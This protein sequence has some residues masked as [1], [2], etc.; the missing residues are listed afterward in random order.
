[1]SSGIGVLYWKII[2]HPVNH[3]TLIHMRCCLRRAKTLLRRIVKG[4]RAGHG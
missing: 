1:M 3:T 4:G 2:D